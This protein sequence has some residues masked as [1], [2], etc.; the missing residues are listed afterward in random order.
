MAVCLVFSMKRFSTE[1]EEKT[2]KKLVLILNVH[3]KPGLREFFKFL[4]FEVDNPA[5][6]HIWVMT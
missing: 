4:M 1:E 6:M 5:P 2:F 3:N